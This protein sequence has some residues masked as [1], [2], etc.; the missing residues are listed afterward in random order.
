MAEI[1]ADD[2]H[3]PLDFWVLAM[4]HSLGGRDAQARPYCCHVLSRRGWRGR[5]AELA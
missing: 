4:I 2:K 5:G 1:K 3:G